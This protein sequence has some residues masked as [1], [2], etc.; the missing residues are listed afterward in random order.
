MNILFPHEK[1]RDTQ[2]NFIND[3]LD[4]VE[5]KKHLIAHVPTGIGKT[6]GILA[7]LLPYAIKNNLTIFFLTPKH[8]QH[9]II[10][11]TLKTIKEKY[12]LN[13]VVADFIGKQGMCLQENVQNMEN[14]EFHNFCN[15]LVENRTCEYYEKFHDSTNKAHFT[16]DIKK[17]LPLHVQDLIEIS[18]LNKL[19]PYE[20]TAEIA[21]DANVV[22]ADYL[23]I[24]H[25]QIR[26]TLFKKINKDIKDCI[27][28]FDEAHNLDKRA[29]ELLSV[30]LSTFLLDLSIKEA[31]RFGLPVIDD[32]LNLKNIL[33][34]FNFNEEILIKK[35]DLTKNI[36]DVVELI[37]SLDYASE[38]V[39]EQQKRSF[40]HHISKFL[41]SWLGQDEGFVR[42]LNKENKGKEVIIKIDYKCL[43]PS[44]V[45]K[46]L[47]ED[48]KL[49]ICMS[50]TLT[51]TSMYKDL[52]G[53]K[54]NTK[55]VE[56]ESTF[57]KENQVNLIVP[58]VTTKFTLRNE[59][60]FKKIAKECSEVVNNVPGNSIIFFPSY[61]ILNK[62][63]R[64][65]N[66]L[67]NKKLF[68]EDS[69]FNKT[70]KEEIIQEFKNNHEKGSV[71]LAVSAASFGE[72]IDLIGDFLKCV[73]IV[74]IPLAKLDLETK[75]LIKY[76]DKKYE[77]GW[78]Y[79]YTYPAIIKAMQNAGRC[80]RS[81]NDRGVIVFLDERYSWPKYKDCFPKDKN[82]ITT[83]LPVDKIKEFF[84][85]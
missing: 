8:T 28:I 62:V 80:I 71:L 85:K 67:C 42:I 15:H 2:D 74:G 83:R 70:E 11:E 50:G 79:A 66:I 45:I 73:V 60:M 12:N 17:K 51:P 35:E 84:K 37:K 32:L 47:I 23:H 13:L 81:E 10:I 16:Q 61:D 33:L 43:D 53:F 20:V 6:A 69:S 76:Y 55:L 14:S 64:E 49:I 58:N 40:I 56:Y 4:S 39:L 31:N 38:I 1:I 22:I 34:N 25:P 63:Y 30:S 77:K 19:C 57:P 9:S 68:I 36:N 29:R 59:L 41:T 7:P 21:K 52:L 65:F 75:E 24:L 46:P 18:R 3:V 54:E 72:G 5:N 27:L 44:L 82:F 26:E 48:S 78:D